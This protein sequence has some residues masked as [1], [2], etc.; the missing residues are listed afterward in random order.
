MIPSFVNPLVTY[1]FW[2]CRFQRDHCW[3]DAMRRSRMV[4]SRV[5][6]SVRY[7]CNGWRIEIA[8]QHLKSGAGLAHPRHCQ[9]NVK[10]SA[11]DEEVAQLCGTEFTPL[12]EGGG[13]VQLEIFAAVEMALLIE[14]IVYG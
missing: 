8:F 6:C 7:E 2:I 5:S 3:P 13:T 12:G 1:K 11:L 14:M 9:N 10:A 4:Y